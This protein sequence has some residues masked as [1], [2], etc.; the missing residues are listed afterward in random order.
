MAAKVVRVPQLFFL[1][2]KCAECPKAVFDF[3]TEEDD[4]GEWVKTNL[5]ISEGDHAVKNG[6]EYVFR[7]GKLQPLGRNDEA[8]WDGESIPDEV[9]LAEVEHEKV[10]PARTLDLLDKRGNLP[11][12]AFL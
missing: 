8:L 5:R 10:L 9:L 1:S 2:K 3:G 7:S 4:L 12:E 6:I 11:V